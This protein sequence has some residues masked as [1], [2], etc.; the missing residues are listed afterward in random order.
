[1][2][3]IFIN[4][5]LRIDNGIITTPREVTTDQTITSTSGATG[6]HDHFIGVDT[7]LGAVTITLPS[8]SS[9]VSGREYKITDIGGNASINNITVSGNGKNISGSS[10]QIISN[11]Y[12]SFTVIFLS[13]SNQWIIH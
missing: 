7:T 1:M 4:D 10:S 13:T 9:R 6:G 3:Q 8:D 11:N 5:D 2:V 12:N